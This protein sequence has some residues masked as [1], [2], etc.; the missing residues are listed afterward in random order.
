[1]ASAQDTSK[2][3]I[4]PYGFVRNYLNVDSR[5]ML[6]VCGSEY[7]MIPYD[8]DRNMAEVEVQTYH[9]DDERFDRNAFTEARLLTF[10]IRF[11]LALEGGCLLGGTLNG[12]VEGDFAGFGTN[13]TVLRLRLVSVTL[14]KQGHELLVGQ[15]WHPLSGSVMSEVL[16]MAAG[17]LFQLCR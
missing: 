11:G 17:A 9:A 8:E 10:S 2:V 7:L 4:K 15:D 12:K 3:R 1:M 14:R 5:R 13:N 16:A 6:T